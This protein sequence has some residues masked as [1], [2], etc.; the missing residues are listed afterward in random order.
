LYGTESCELLESLGSTRSGYK[1]IE[2]ADRFLLPTQA[3]SRGHLRNSWQTA[4]I[5]FDSVG[6]A[7]DAPQQMSGTVIKALTNTEINPRTQEVTDPSCI[8]IAPQLTQAANAKFF[9]NSCDCFRVESWSVGQ[10]CAFG[11]QLLDGALQAGE[12]SALDDFSDDLADRLADPWQ[13]RQVI[14][15]SNKPRNVLTQSLDRF[16]RTSIRF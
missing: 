12:F 2:I 11:R 6:D 3:P 8:Q 7:R 5:V 9:V 16:S 13:L 1:K 10:L 14:S 4:K 15:L